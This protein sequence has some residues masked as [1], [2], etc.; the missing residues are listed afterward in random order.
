M[1]RYIVLDTHPLPLESCPGLI[2]MSPLP[3]K[4]LILHASAFPHPAD[5]LRVCVT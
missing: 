2:G 4:A 5:Y 1:L 3:D